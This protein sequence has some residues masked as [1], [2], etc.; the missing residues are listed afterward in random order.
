MCVVDSLES[1]A[2][3][4]P[5]STATAVTVLLAA[6][7][8]ASAIGLERYHPSAGSERSGYP[9]SMSEYHTMQVHDPLD[10]E[11]RGGPGGQTAATRQAKRGLAPDQ[12]G[13][14]ETG[15]QASAEATGDDESEEDEE[16]TGNIDDMAAEIEADPTVDTDDAVQVAAALAEKEQEAAQ[17]RASDDV[18]ES[19]TA[20]M[21]RELQV[22]SNGLRSWATDF[23]ER[24]AI[25]STVA[26]QLPSSVAAIEA[27][28]VQLHKSFVHNINAL[29]AILFRVG[30]WA[31]SIVSS[32][33][34]Q[35]YWQS[36]VQLSQFVAESRF[37]LSATEGKVGIAAITKNAMKRYKKMVANYD[38]MAAGQ[39]EAVEEEE[40]AP[41][42]KRKRRLRRVLSLL[43]LG[44]A[45]VLSDANVT[46]A[47]KRS[48]SAHATATAGTKAPTNGTLSFMSLGRSAPAPFP[49]Q[50]TQQ[51]GGASTPPWLAAV[52]AAEVNASDQADAITNLRSQLGAAGDG[53][54]DMGER[55]SAMSDQ[56]ACVKNSL[57]DLMAAGATLPRWVLDTYL[58]ADIAARALWQMWMLMIISRGSG[59][60][61]SSHVLRVCM[62]YLNTLWTSTVAR[63]GASLGHGAMKWLPADS[64]NRALLG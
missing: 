47:P 23:Q 64:Y 62:L 3:M 41:P 31:T 34:F 48:A 20:P 40:E 25:V 32:P 53:L 17:A 44:E 56:M 16:E 33:Y 49:P 19:P 1:Q 13:T 22:C 15:V 54:S 52:K 14:Y 10:H 37:H 57:N 18:D 58:Q 55:A 7:E 39:K 21:W 43:Q 6:L 9:P 5:L 26:S 28:G 42:S 38:E 46:A 36:V 2:Q 4:S 35:Q 45:A 11:R 63:T 61:L 50:A 12:H 24:Q 60:E 51:A 29:Q 8:G 30:W 27:T 59:Y